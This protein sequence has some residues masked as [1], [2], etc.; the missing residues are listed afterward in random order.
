MGEQRTLVYYTY[1]DRQSALDF[2]LKVRNEWDT[3][4]IGQR[5]KRRIK[6][7]GIPYWWPK[8]RKKN[9]AAQDKTLCIPGVDYGKPRTQ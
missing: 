3:V 2:A 7:P 8:A 5:D 4:E 1:P 9:K 6:K